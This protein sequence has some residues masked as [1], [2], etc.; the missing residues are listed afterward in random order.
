MKIVFYVV[1]MK[2]IE[3]V[4][5]EVIWSTVGLW[6]SLV[7]SF[8]LWTFYQIGWYKSIWHQI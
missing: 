6:A 1:P 3:A 8:P 2:I 7:G 5:K 4:C